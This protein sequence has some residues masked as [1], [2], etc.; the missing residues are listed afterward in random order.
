MDIIFTEE[1]EKV[2][3]Q[4]LYSRRKKKIQKRNS[5]MQDTDS[6]N[7]LNMSENRFYIHCRT[8][9]R[10]QTLYSERQKKK[11]KKK[12]MAISEMQNTK[13]AIHKRRRPIFWILGPTPS[14][15]LSKIGNF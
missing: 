12:E 13:G 15:L 3:K 14:P 10:Q 2:S 8:K 5:K 4:S 9:K 11:T 7:I 6:Q 1:L